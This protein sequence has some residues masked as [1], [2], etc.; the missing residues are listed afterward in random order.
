MFQNI[1]IAYE[2]VF[3]YWGYAEKWVLRSEQNLLLF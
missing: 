3:K 2:K 1:I